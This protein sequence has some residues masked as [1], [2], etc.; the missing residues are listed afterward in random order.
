MIPDPFEG[1]KTVGTAVM[2]EVF[3]SGCLDGAERQEL[4]CEL[5]RKEGATDV[6]RLVNPYSTWKNPDE[7][8][9]SYDAARPDSWLYIPRTL[10]TH[11][12]NTL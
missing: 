8:L 7:T 4:K 1:W 10:P 3:V 2:T 5:Q 12:S 11:G 6:Y 9:F